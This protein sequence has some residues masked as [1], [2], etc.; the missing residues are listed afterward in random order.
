L[1][2]T[3][4]IDWTTL[5]P[6]AVQALTGVALRVE[7]RTPAPKPTARFRPRETAVKESA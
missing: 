7:R 5:C 3:W 1:R 4:S 2:G 6:G